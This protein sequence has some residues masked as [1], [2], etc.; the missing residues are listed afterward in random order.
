MSNNLDQL[1][2]LRSLVPILLEKEKAGLIQIGF[3]Q[4]AES[5]VFW[6][7]NRGMWTDKQ[8]LLV[9][10]LIRRAKRKERNVKLDISVQKFDLDSVVAKVIEKIGD[11]RVDVE[12]VIKKVEPRVFAALDARK[13]RQVEIVVTKQ[14][15]R[16]KVKGPH[17]CK[18]ESLL[19]AANSRL[20]NGY[21]PGIFLQGEASSGKTTGAK[22]L[23]EA[24]GLEWHFNG[25][26][27]FPHEMLGFIDGAGKYHRTP[28]REAY[29]HGGVYT[30]DEVDRS[31]PVAL[32]AVNPHLANGVATF[33]DK[34]VERHKDCIIVCTANTWGL[35]A[36]A[37]YSG[38][39]KLDAAFLSRF[40]VRIN[41]DIDA[42]L[43][44]QIVLNKE[45]LDKV[46]AVR[47]RAR[48]CGLKVMIDTRIAQAGAALIAQG[49][50]M[51][52]AADMTY[53]ANLKPDQR[54]QLKGG[55]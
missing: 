3:G 46:R 9:G 27:S 50:N 6:A 14:D 2:E 47:A 48:A 29:E 1:E 35:G 40:P 8:A 28:F 53:L 55:M 49:Y 44:E 25:A 41:W 30:F 23:S 31:D 15:G 5:L 34:Q 39:T 7:D 21:A 51:E 12:E 45:W 19:R 42:A 37:N 24:L 10:S 36:D 33:P 13:P 20:P 18:F 26:I 16:Q 52:E 11:Q 38:A 4:K 54:T 17:H 43:E 22:M 32:L